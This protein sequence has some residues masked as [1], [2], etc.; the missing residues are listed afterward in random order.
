MQIRQSKGHTFCVG[1]GNVCPICHS[2]QDNHM[3]S[4]MYS[5]RTLKMKVKDVDNLDE[6]W[7]E[8]RNCSTCIG[9]QK[10]AY[11]G[12]AV[13]SRYTI[14]HFVTDGRTAALPV[15]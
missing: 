14:V 1:S 5:I 10:F 7:H 3:H 15:R 11:L 8:G 13:C 6:N 4:P 9:R 12:I 2:L